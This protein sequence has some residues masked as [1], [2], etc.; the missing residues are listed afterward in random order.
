MRKLHQKQILDLLKTLDKAIDEIK[1]LLKNNQTPAAINLLA[2]CQDGA[3]NIGEFI[4]EIQGEGT[5]TVGLLVEFSEMLYKASTE[6]NDESTRNKFA[7][8]LQDKLRLIKNS[9]NNELKPDKI[10]IAF[11]PYK[12]SM[13]DSLESIY[14]AAKN[15]PACDAYV[16]PIPYYDRLPGG[17]FGQM[18]YEGA[19]YPSN[20]PITDWQAYNVEERKPDIIFVHNPYD[21][22]NYVTSVHPNF[23]CERLKDLTDCLVYVPYFVCTGDE[24]SEHFCV[25]PGTLYTHKVIVQSESI[26]QEYI[27]YFK[28]FE[29]KNNCRAVF[30]KPEDKFVALGSPKFDKAINS[31]PE[32]FALPPEWQRLIIKPD[33]TK[34]KVFFYNT[35][36][37]AILDGDEKYLQ[38]IR[39]ALGVF[40]NAPDVVL[41]WRP[42]PLNE[43]TYQVMRPR[44]LDE[45]ERIIGEYKS[46]GW[47]IFD[48]S[49]DLHRAIAWSDVYYGDASSVM[50][51][52]D[53]V[54]K[55]VVMQNVEVGEDVETERN[56]WLQENFLDRVFFYRL[57]VVNDEIWFCD[58]HSNSFFKMNR[59]TLEHEYVESFAYSLYN[60]SYL[61]GTFYKERMYFVPRF[62]NKIAE[63]DIQK[64]TMAYIPYDNIKSDAN[65][66]TALNYGK[67]IYFTPYR[68][69]AIMRL[70]TE[71]RQIDF[72]DDWFEPLKQLTTDEKQLSFIIPIKI[73]ENT[74]MF[75]V[76]GTNAV[77]EFNMETL[78][79]KVYEIGQKAYQYN[80]ICYDGINYWLSPLYN[81]PVVKWNPDV[82]VI[83]EFANVV[84]GCL[85]N[86]ISFRPIIFS[87]GYVWL[88]PHYSKRTL[89]INI[90]TDEVLEVEE[91]NPNFIEG[92]SRVNSVA[93]T[94]SQ[95]IGSVI[96]AY[97][98]RD[99][100]FIE[101]N[102]KTQK[103][104]EK[105]LKYSPAVLEK[106]KPMLGSFLYRD[107]A[108]CQKVWEYYY[109]EH[110]SFVLSDCI[111]F[112]YEINFYNSAKKQ[113]FNAMNNN[114][115]GTAGKM[116]FDF[117]K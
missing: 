90:K 55:P 107:I 54:G 22:N 116:I 27:K 72:F 45:Y 34:K 51:M 89:R 70:D 63:Y 114:A 35:T 110:P 88:F 67:Y 106:I 82:G 65:F 94:C 77:V 19:E 53:A 112:N 79:S 60:Y 31:K 4:E 32:D 85:P 115:D 64:K 18:H 91:L 29:K 75:T 12:A 98:G 83:K 105:I 49:P 23:Y 97:D 113:L 50:A 17:A 30:G 84:E 104:R 10:E 43:T 101:Y 37:A 95:S 6:I 73:T 117:L 69:K 44:L 5:K 62:T 108:K 86:D 20:I 80:G 92:E 111:N 58:N 21:A 57:F 87:E 28:E 48:D 42:H 16:V 1:R 24:V 41:L 103:K 3:V 11:F 66:Q 68:Y 52:F 46:E 100:T 109:Y 39:H 59:E 61:V 33:G 93:Y 7:N 76:C 13:W 47:G 74:I 78:K 81:G 96:Y 15:D 8:Q 36:I 99:G 40:R 26:R 56:K 38:K 2:D 71:S 102:C 14:L 25:L 9:V